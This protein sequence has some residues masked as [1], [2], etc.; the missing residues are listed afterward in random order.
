[1]KERLQ[2]LISAAGIASRRRAEELIAA[3]RVSV[4]GV[5][6]RQLGT[7]A[8][9]VKDTIRVDG[10]TIF[11]GKTNLYIALNKPEGVVTTMSDP[12]KRPTVVELLRDVPERV[13][14]VG[15]LDY[16][17]SGLLL[18][19]NDGDF[20]QRV[21]HPSFQIP[22]VYR[23]K[24]QGHI[25]KKEIKKLGEGIVLPD[26][27]IFRPENIT[28]EKFNEKSSWL[29]LTLR[30]GK[31]RI[32]RKGFDAAGYRVSRLRRESIGPVSLGALKEGSWRHL[33]RKE[34]TDLLDLAARKKAKNS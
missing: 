12:Q 3:G 22:K 1:M 2:K 8:D 11:A 17:S 21:Q 15:R 24:I 20:A 30:E 6:V 28:L 9:S 18:L 13:Y 7:K 33:S 16:D 25:P 5:V 4:N 26:A 10:N 31:N 34:I 14:P 27:T 29:K 32:I 23:V 19:T